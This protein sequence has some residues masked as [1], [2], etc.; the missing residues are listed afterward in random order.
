MVA[1]DL[2][3]T[4]SRLCLYK[5]KFIFSYNEKSDLL[6]KYPSNVR[7]TKKKCF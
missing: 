6:E 4:N 2:N 5:N 1:H 7:I 3:G